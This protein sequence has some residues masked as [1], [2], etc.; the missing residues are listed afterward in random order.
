MA[1]AA[2]RRGVDGRRFRTGYR[3]QNRAQ[4]SE[5][6]SGR[7]GT[8]RCSNVHDRSSSAAT[9]CQ[10]F[11]APSLRSWKATA[12]RPGCAAVSSVTAARP[13]RE[14]RAP[15]T[16]KK[17]L[18]TC[19]SVSSP[20][21]TANPTGCGPSWKTCADQPGS[22][23]PASSRSWRNRP[24]SSGRV[25]VNADIS[26]RNM[27]QSCS[28]CGRRRSSAAVMVKGGG[29]LI[30]KNL[31]RDWQRFRCRQFIAPSGSRSSNETPLGTVVASVNR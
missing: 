27:V 21:R 26:C 1:V 18:I 6:S 31:R 14:R 3:T 29:V 5:G 10:N 28:S 2:T 19:S 25:P 4:E 15:C 7:P 17:L 11:A 20:R 24:R 9:V 13:M 8:S 22:E 16:T 23:R 12:H 30:R